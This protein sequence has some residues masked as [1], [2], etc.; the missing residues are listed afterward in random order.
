MSR[1]FLIANSVVLLVVSLSGSTCGGHA[2]AAPSLPPAPKLSGS[3]TLSGTVVANQEREPIAGAVLQLTGI[4]DPGQTTVTTDARGGFALQVPGSII[5]L[6]MSAPGYLNRGSRISVSGSH[7]DVIL[8][9]IR[10]SPPFS[11][12]FY[13][14]IARNGYEES[15]LQPLRPWTI[16]PSFY[17]RTVTED[18]GEA[19]PS[20]IINGVK[21][22]LVNAV[23][24]L[25]GGR[26]SV[27][28]LETGIDS[29]S[30]Q[31]GWVLVTFARSLGGDG[32]RA[33][34][35]GNSGNIWLLYDPDDPT[36]P[37]NC[38]SRTVAAADHE[39]VHTMGYYHT[40][41]PWGSLAFDFQSGQG[42]PGV[43]RPARTTYHAA[44]MYSRR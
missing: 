21:R 11:L 35:G 4:T 33:T 7:S 37:F 3:Y 28:S 34:V 9:L 27:A 17:I 26:L 40:G 22:V 29:R 16:A 38:E 43:G 42:C 36:N 44:V 6:F 41:P 32:G 2:P 30:S 39:I 10:A 1:R 12:E 31:D 24:E 20:P 18:T 5:R 23:P 25:T 14:Q 8:D 13:R 19:I 15:F